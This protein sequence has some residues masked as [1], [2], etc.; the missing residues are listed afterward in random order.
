MPVWNNNRRLALYTLRVEL[1]RRVFRTADST[2][3]LF[4]ANFDASGGDLLHAISS[5]IVGL[6]TEGLVERDMRHFGQATDV[7]RRGRTIAW[8]MEGGESGRSS[9]IMLRKGDEWQTREPSGIERAPYWAFAV[10]PEN[11]NQAW[12]M[13]EKDGNRSLPTEWR[14]ELV[15]R[16]AAAYR[17]Y[18]LVI[19]TVR[20]ASLWSQVESSADN[21]LL[22]FEVALRSPD[23]PSSSGHAAGFEQG[24]VRIDRR[25][26]QAA[27]PGGVIGKK[28]REFRRAFTGRRTPHGVL[29]VDEPLDYD[30]LADERN[31]IRLR[32]NVVEIKATVLNA[33]GRPKTVVFEGG[34]DPVQ[35]IEMAG[36]SSGIP[37]QDH[38]VTECQS[39]VRDLAQS[40]GVALPSGWETG[41]WTHPDNAPR[42][43]VR[44]SD[45][46]DA[47]S[48]TQGAG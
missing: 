5:F 6:P 14:D 10:V 8:R 11:S 35:T 36:T 12:L 40:G 19:G 9:S 39:A 17:G 2:R 16:F 26:Y 25:I 18:R 15:K 42:M 37:S 4:V 23:N 38:F 27:E 28:L 7:R 43:E 3:E 32:D 33:E 31:Q 30:D 34:R 22:G 47:S 48:T 20:E 44:A 24:M 41:E 29:E 13:V 45:S 21:R 1:D 46:P